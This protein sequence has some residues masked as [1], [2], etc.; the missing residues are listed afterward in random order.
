MGG[1]ASSQAK[2]TWSTSFLTHMRKKRSGLITLG[3][4]R[5]WV[6]GEGCVKTLFC[7]TV[8]SVLSSFAIIS[9]RK[10]ELV[11]LL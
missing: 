6:G 5:W 2:G 3:L 7:N 8:L 9:V 11:A 1:W 4:R 10:K